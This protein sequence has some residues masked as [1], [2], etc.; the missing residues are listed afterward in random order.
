[1]TERGKANALHNNIHNVDFFAANLMEPPASAPWMQRRYD[2]ILLDPPRAGAKEILPAN[3]KFNAKRI[4]YV[5][6]NP[7]TLARDAGELVQPVQISLANVGIMKCFL[8]HHTLKQWLYLKRTKYGYLNSNSPSLTGKT[9]PARRT[10]KGIGQ[11]NAEHAGSRPAA[12]T[13]NHAS[14]QS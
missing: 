12:R 13:A 7:A 5:S 4:V 1:M 2:K 8:I 11:R 3:G 6:C 9:A 14:A 10:Q